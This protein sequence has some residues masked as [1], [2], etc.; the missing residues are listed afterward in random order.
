MSRKQEFIDFVRSGQVLLPKDQWKKKTNLYK[1]WQ[2]RVDENDIR[3][4]LCQGDVEKF[5]DSIYSFL[6]H[7][8]DEFLGEV[9]DGSFSSKK[10]RD[11][12]NVNLVNNTTICNTPNNPGYFRNICFEEIVICGGDADINLSIK[13]AITNTL[14]GKIRKTFFMPALFEDIFNGKVSSNIV[15]TFNKSCKLVSIFSPNVYRYLLKCLKKH[16]TNSTSI[17][18]STA[19]WGVPVIAADTLDYDI[20]DI[21]DVQNSVLQKCHTI[22]NEL[23]QNK[24]TLFD[25][26]YALETHHTPSEV[27]DQIINKKYDHMISCPPYYDLEIYGASDKQSTDLYKT[28]PDW[29]E[30]YWRKTVIASKNLL[31]EDGVF[32]FVMGHHVRYQYM[33]RDMVEIAK[34]EGFKLVEEIKIVPKRKTDNMYLSPVEKYEVCSIFKI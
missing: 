27:M 21:V 26:V 13:N 5:V 19:S 10:F 32:S 30:N 14:N 29:L 20:V 15:L 25:N 17:L 34:Q 24:N 18:F 31:N 6:E 16:S 2:Q 33:S 1:I 4:K 23:D 22:K 12:D 28:Y 11:I 3:Y 8:L 9:Y 7:H